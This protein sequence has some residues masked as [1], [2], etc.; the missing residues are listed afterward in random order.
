[1]TVVVGFLCTDGVVIAADSMLT[2]VIGGVGVGHHHGK[3]ISVLQ[4]PQLFAFAGDV[5]IAMRFRLLA[6]VNHATIAGTQNTLDFPIQISQAIMQQLKA[7]EA[8]GQAGGTSTVLAFGH[9]GQAH[10]CVFE[11]GLQPRLLDADHY[12]FAQGSGKLSADPF[13][14]FLADIFCVAGRPSVRDA[15]FLATWA[16]QHVIEVNPGGV[17]P[18]IRLATFELEGATFVAREMPENEIAEHREAVASA[19]EALRQWRIALGAAAQ[20]GQ[21]GIILAGGDDLSEPQPEAPNHPA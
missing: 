2:P 18:P 17:A 15:V 1:M 14:R 4:G 11:S 5:G 20:P 12:Y 21:D 19:A 9:Q 7:T 10:C 3:K 8:L 13:L 16:V 6:D